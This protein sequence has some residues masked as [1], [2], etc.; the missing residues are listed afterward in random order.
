MIRMR[1]D[2]PLNWDDEVIPSKSDKTTNILGFKEIGG[3]GQLIYHP[4]CFRKYELGT[5]KSGNCCATPFCRPGY[6]PVLLKENFLSGQDLLASLCNLA[7]QVNSFEN[8][9]PHT[10]LIIDW[11]M[12]NM[13]PYSIDFI[14]SELNESFDIN[15]FD[16]EIVE[17][18]GIFEIDTFLNDLR[19]LYNAVM[20]Y[21]ALET[22]CITNNETAYDL[23][24]EGKYFECYSFF[25][26]YKHTTATAPDDSDYE[27][28]KGNL[29]E[30]MRI[31]NEYIKNHPA[32][33][34]PA[35]ES[36]TTPYD[37][38]KGLRN[39][40]ID[41]IPEFKMKLKVDPHTNKLEFYTNVNSV[42]DIAWITLAR[43]LS[44]G[45]APENKGKPDNRPEGIMIR[46]RNCG[47]F[48]IRKNNRQ[49]FCDAEEC[50]KARNSR[51][52]KA[53]RERKAIERVQTSK[54]RI[55]TP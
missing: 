14:Y 39:A 37:D 1:N 17:Q 54:K 41:I 36:A 47:K 10:Q 9:V 11:C 52:Q 43:M 46:C 4:F 53:Y 26:K 32:G 15:S 7:M 30:E 24:K 51:K 33:S 3:V 6:E 38:Y 19:K 23:S 42:F 40:L 2:M 8:K 45:L 44:E 25:D 50:Q 34:P 28:T 21:V 22:I 29:I 27:K 48:I 49:E 13:H 12:N 31:D 55:H 20:F 35:N 18:D 5:D 16:A